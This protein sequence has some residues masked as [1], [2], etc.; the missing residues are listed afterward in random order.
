MATA[1]KVEDRERMAPA[2]PGQM[3]LVWR[4][5]R[6][7]KLGLIGLVTLSILVVSVVVVPM[8]LPFNYEQIDEGALSI[9]PVTNT[10]FKPMWFSSPMTVTTYQ[11]D[12]PATVGVD[13][14]YMVNPDGGKLHILGT[15]ELGRDNM[16]RLFYAGRISLA[17]GVITTIIV[18]IIGAIVGALAGFYGGWVD[19]I[20]MRLV[21][22]MLS[23]PT[24]P[25][26]LVLSQGLGK[27]AFMDNLFGPGLGTIATIIM[28]LSF[29][30]WLTL[31][32][33]VRGS[34]LSLRS[35]DFIE[36]TRALG[37]NNR[38]I[39]TR[40]L[41]PNSFAPIIV[42]ATLAVGDFIVSESALSFLG[43]GIQAPTPSWGNIMENSREY[44][45]FITNM[46]P[47]DE[48][49]GYM[50]IFP[51]LLILITVLSINFV[52][53]ALRDALDPRLKT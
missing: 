51:G 38:R 5:F 21:D 34:I 3:A 2:E 11:L 24:L 37:A 28:V 15:N 31:S 4:R 45:G 26:L 14:S 6:K 47:F 19:T 42:A 44:A 53:D 35:L 29:F 8:L 39:I 40:H 13:E 16:A 30:G 36:A 7:H 48:I 43:L 17:V 52:G 1:A 12:D 33:L 41:M 46:N 22:L 20:L 27:S 50:I 18:V 49:R 9:D 10:A 23:L 32:R 25:I